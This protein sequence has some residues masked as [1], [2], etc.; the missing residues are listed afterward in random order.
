MCLVRSLPD[1]E[2]PPPEKKPRLLL[3]LAFIVYTALKN[4]HIKIL[5]PINIFR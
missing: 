3:S 4:D 5:T 1:Y 2:T